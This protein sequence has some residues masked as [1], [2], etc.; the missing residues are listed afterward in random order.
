MV[1]AC[2]KGSETIHDY[3]A[4]DSKYY[5]KNVVQNIVDKSETLEPFP[6]VGRMIPEINDTDITAI[7][8]RSPCS[9]S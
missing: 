4:Q 9:P 7:F 8:L 5:A 6:K 3:L 2:Q 1:W